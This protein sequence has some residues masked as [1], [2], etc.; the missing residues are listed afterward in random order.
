MPLLQGLGRP[1]ILSG[2]FPA[3]MDWAGPTMAKKIR[4]ILFDLGEPLLDFGHV[5]VH[6]LFKDG[7]KLAYEYL[8]SLDQPLPSFTGYHLRQL[9]AIRWRYFLSRFTRREFNSLELISSLGR[10]MGHRLSESQNLELSWLW[11][12]PLSNQSRAEDGLLEMLRGFTAAGLTL[13]VI[14]NTFIAG[15]VL[16]R[17]LRAEGLEELLPIRVYSSEVGYR[18]PHRRIFEIALQRAELPPE[19]TIFVGDSPRIDVKGANQAGLVSVLK[20]AAGRRTR[21]NIRPRHRIGSLTELCH[22]VAQYNGG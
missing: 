4:G 12:K 7:A 9:W 6:S 18:K 1:G 10:R 19:A 8:Q 20:D 14:S 21:S 11:Y 13:G 17:H 16:D 5:N 2:V 15:K 3:G 22:I